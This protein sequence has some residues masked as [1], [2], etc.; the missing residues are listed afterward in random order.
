MPRRSNEFQQLVKLIETQ[1]ASDRAVVRESVLLHDAEGDRRE[2]DVL[3][4]TKI[5][6][7]DVRIAVEC[8]D[9]QRR[10]D[11]TWIE[12]L[13]GKYE[14]LPIHKVIAVSRRGFSRAA[15]DKAAR[16]KIAALS[17]EEAREEDW[18]NAVY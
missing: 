1:L 12:Q 6:Q 7:H 15:L 9:H 14:G 5:G 17:L 18:L 10:A 2:I 13:M 11:K 16:H 3:I 8:R 4:E